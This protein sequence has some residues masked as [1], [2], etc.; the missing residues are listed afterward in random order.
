MMMTLLMD[1][2]CETRNEA[3]CVDSTYKEDRWVLKT[4]TDDRFYVQLLKIDSTTCCYLTCVSLWLLSDGFMS[5]G[6]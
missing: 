5:P 2:F 6:P 4:T 1:L 3:V